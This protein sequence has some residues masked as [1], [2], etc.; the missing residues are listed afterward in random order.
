M[1]F[2]ID[3]KIFLIAFLF[4]VTSQIKVYV[5]MM[6]CAI[7]HELGHLLVGILLGMKP[8]RLELIPIGIRVIFKLNI[9]DIN[10]KVKRTNRL[11]VKKIFVALAGPLV[12]LILIYVVACLKINLIYK[13]NFIYANF[14]LLIVNLVPIY[15][16]DGGRILKG[17]ILIFCGK[18]KAEGIM[19]VFSIIMS[20]IVT[21]IGS[22][23]FISNKNIAIVFFLIYMWFIV[24]QERKFVKNKKLI[25]EILGKTIEKNCE[26]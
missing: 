22:I 1:R 5:I 25:Y 18:E 17:I 10:M 20:V 23:A 7:I 26:K 19:S 11:E 4:F 13:I 2:K 14:L 12:N 24:I 16:L 9:K 6:I 15:P 21:I 8:E 3:L